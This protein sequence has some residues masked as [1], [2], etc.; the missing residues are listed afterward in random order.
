MGR[1]T[2]TRAT[3]HSS[4]INT[5][6]VSAYTQFIVSVSPADAFYISTCLAR[7]D[8]P[9]TPLSPIH[10]TCL[11]LSES[12]TYLWP[13]NAVT[14]I[15]ERNKSFRQVPRADPAREVPAFPL[16]GK[17]IYAGR[18]SI[19]YKSHHSVGFDP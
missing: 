2:S 16:I 7:W 3:I 5:F 18:D 17:L 10:R 6:Y 15:N 13:C 4:K 14:L 12:V 11:G 19:Q 9:F 1:V 8:L